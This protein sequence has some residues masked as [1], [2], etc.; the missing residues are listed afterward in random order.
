MEAAAVTVL[1]VL[2][3]SWCVALVATLALGQ[4][5]A[6]FTPGWFVRLLG[7][8][9][10]LFAVATW[11]AAVAAVCVYWPASSG[12]APALSALAVLIG[13]GVLRCGAHVLRVVSSIHSGRVFKR[14]ARRRGEVLLV[15][16]IV[17]E[18]FAVPGR[19]GVVVVTTALRDA[20]SP[21]EL[22]AVVR[23][24]HAHL[25]GRHHFFVQAVEVAVCL[26]PLLYRWRAAV[27]FAAE[28]HADESA[29]QPDRDAAARAVAKVALVRSQ[30]SRSRTTAL[31]I[32][33]P[34]HVVVRRVRALKRPGPI[35]QRRGA[36]AVALALLVFTAFDLGI[37]AD[38][39][40]DRIA[41]EP[42]ESSPVLL[43]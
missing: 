16:D 6:V 3:A 19:R 5:E 26:N 21:A 17:P 28:R 13:F 15:D 37:T 41:P 11:T 33:G 23:H 32:A 35:R 22:A 27:R 42:G 8:S 38:L 40:Q 18:A 4:L 24:E 9:S 39:V 29:A 31:G 2:T 25:R 30:L 43:R 36:A 1:A 7:A 20:L 12:R 34:D 14:R 10:L